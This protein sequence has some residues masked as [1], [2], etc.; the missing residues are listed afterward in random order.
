MWMCD[1]KDDSDSNSSST[2]TRKPCPPLPP[3]SPFPVF[4]LP[5][6]KHRPATHLTHISVHMLKAIMCS[7]V[8]AIYT[9]VVVWA[10]LTGQSPHPAVCVTINHGRRATTWSLT[11]YWQ[12]IHHYFSTYSLNSASHS[13]VSCTFSGASIQWNFVCHIKLYLVGNLHIPLAVSNIL[14]HVYIH[15]MEHIDWTHWK[16]LCLWRF[17]SYRNCFLI[18]FVRHCLYR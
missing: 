10:G 9:K 7:G 12:V 18:F 14:L 11:E 6:S 2:N 15:A 3:P 4:S 16:Y 8:L 1:V 13:G 17:L 5:S